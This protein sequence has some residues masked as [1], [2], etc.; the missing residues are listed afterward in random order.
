MSEK[1]VRLELTPEQRERLKQAT[2]KEVR[3]VKLN[4]EQ[5]EARTTPRLIGN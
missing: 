2:G 1:A 4:L 3:E 5:L